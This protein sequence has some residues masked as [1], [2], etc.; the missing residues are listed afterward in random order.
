MT[1]FRDEW[2]TNTL[3]QLIGEDALEELKQGD[4]VA[5]SLWETAVARKA[6]TD[7]EIL[8]TLAT[9]F[10]VKIADLAQMQSSAKDV[11]TEAQARKYHILPVRATD[12]YLEIA[13]ANPFDLDCEKNLAFATGREVRLL[14]ASPVVIAEHLDELYGSENVMQRI[15]DGMGD[16]EVDITTVEEA[17][18]EEDLVI[19][20]GRGG[21]RPPRPPGIGHFDR[22]H[23]ERA[24]RPRGRQ[25]G[26]GRRHLGRR[27][28]L[29]GFGHGR[30]RTLPAL[31]LRARGGRGDAL[32]EPP[33]WRSLRTRAIARGV[34]RRPRRL[35]RHR[36]PRRDQPALLDGGHAARLD[37]RRWSAPCRLAE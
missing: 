30:R 24:A 19:Y 37:R 13:T 5:S 16:S 9:K 17:P 34:A 7:S 36:P 27:R 26:S 4:D 29:R 25:P 2:L 20:G 28:D 11:V 33:S 1:Q 14:L 35:H 21:A 18:E 22:G 6:A 8:S 32:R 31:R 12:S 3:T 10:R 15:L 23:D